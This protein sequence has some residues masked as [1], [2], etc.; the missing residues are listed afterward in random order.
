[1]T[2][3]NK[4]YFIILGV[5]VLALLVKSFVLDQYK[6]QGDEQ[7]FFDE[8]TQIMEQRYDSGIYTWLVKTRLVKMKVMS[9]SEKTLTDDQG[10]EYVATGKYK[11]RIRKYVF[12][13]LPF[14]E[15]WILDIKE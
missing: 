8:A 3:E 11:A 14:A 12:G 4:I 13:V 9:E 2:K 10:N 5:L 1:M 15:E 7:S 6:P